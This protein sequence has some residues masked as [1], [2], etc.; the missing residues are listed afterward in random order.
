MAT[1][2]IIDEQLEPIPGV[3]FVSTE[4]WMNMLDRQTRELLG[5]SCA[6][7]IR[8]Y[9]AGE[10]EDPSSSDVTFLVMMIPHSER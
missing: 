7:F 10:I 3:D 1:A 8:R 2:P 9:K 6:E 5:M 4:E